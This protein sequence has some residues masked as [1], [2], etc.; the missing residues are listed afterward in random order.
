MMDV[1]ADIVLSLTSLD[2]LGAIAPP[3]T[4]Q[5]KFLHFCLGP[6]D[7]ALLPVEYIAEVLRV[8]MTEV[9]PVPQ[10][11]SCVL[12]IYNRRSEMLWLVDLGH[13]VGYPLRFESC[14]ALATEMVIVLE[15]EGQYLGLVVP[16]VNDIEWYD[17]QQL[18]PPSV[19]LF[20]PK[21]LPFV[22]GYFKGSDST[23]LDAVAIV[24]SACLRVRPFPPTTA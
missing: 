20:S 19:Q 16:Q 6:E 17:P 13:L 24:Q 8:P 2:L 14:N 5:Q 1:S 22:Q 21:L 18:Q 23:V 4:L 15:V 3:V 7:T 12:G 11:P 10:M 9:L